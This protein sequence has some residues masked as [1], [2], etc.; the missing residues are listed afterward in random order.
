MASLH[1]LEGGFFNCPFGTVFL[2]LMFSALTKVWILSRIQVLWLL[3]PKLKFGMV[4][5]S[6]MINPTKHYEPVVIPDSSSPDTD[7]EEHC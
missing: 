5:V 4:I 6:N 7:S 2:E 1:S 3:Y